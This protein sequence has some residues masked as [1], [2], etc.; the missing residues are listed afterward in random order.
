MIHPFLD[1]NGRLGCLLITFLLCVAGA[2][3]E[4]ILYLSLYF[5][6]TGRK[7]YELLDC[8][9]RTEIGRKLALNFS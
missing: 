4:P 8:V 6:R 7:D 2:I 5:S 1:G 9:V 3:S